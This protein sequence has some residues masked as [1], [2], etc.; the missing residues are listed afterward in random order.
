MSKATELTE[1]SEIPNP[2]DE[3]EEERKRRLLM[4]TFPEIS[5]SSFNKPLTKQEQWFTVALGLG[6]GLALIGSAII[7]E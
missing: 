7:D 3:T 1:L 6:V 2:E 5:S 4:S